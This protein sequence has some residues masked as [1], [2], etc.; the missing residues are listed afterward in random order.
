V[1]VVTSSLNAAMDGVA[2]Q[3]LKLHAA[4]LA[5]TVLSEVQMGVRSLDATGPEPFEAPFQEWTWRL[6]LTPRES[7]TGESSGLTLLEVIIERDDASV[8]HR[9][10]QVLKLD[11]SKRGVPPVPAVEGNSVF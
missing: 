2:R 1:A 6:A 4:N 8:I 5:V 7:E 10:A 3:K 9:V 11:G